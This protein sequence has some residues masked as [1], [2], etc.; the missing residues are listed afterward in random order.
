MPLQVEG[1]QGDGRLGRVSE[2]LVGGGVSGLQ[3]G[4]EGFAG[5]ELELLAGGAPGLLPALQCRKDDVGALGADVMEVVGDGA[6][7]VPAGIGVQLVED[8][9]GCVDRERDADGPREGGTGGLAGQPPDPVIRMLRPAVDGRHRL[10]GEVGDEVPGS[11]LRGEVGRHPR[12]G[13]QRAGE[14]VDGAAVPGDVVG[15]RG[16]EVQ[17]EVRG[18]ARLFRS[19]GQ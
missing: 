7:H 4:P 11:V 5:D 6:G 13:V 17:A 1:G 14:V 15:V 10:L 18:D 3:Q 19:G 2:E 12:E 8:G 9:H 16:V